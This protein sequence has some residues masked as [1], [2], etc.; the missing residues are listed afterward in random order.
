MLSGAGLVV[1]FPKEGGWSPLLSLDALA[2]SNE[3][4]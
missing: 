3:M 1:R 4:M 2:K